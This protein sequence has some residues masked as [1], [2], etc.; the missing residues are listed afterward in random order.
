MKAKIKKHYIYKY[1]KF[2]KLFYLYYFNM[3][4]VIMPQKF[5]IMYIFIMFFI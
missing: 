2:V 4:F 5:I 1:Y 3:I